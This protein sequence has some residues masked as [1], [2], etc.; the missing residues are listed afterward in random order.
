MQSSSFLT[1]HII[2]INIKKRVFSN[3]DFVYSD[4]AQRGHNWESFSETVTIIS[5]TNT[6]IKKANWIPR[7][8]SERESHWN[9][10]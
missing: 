9:Y 6:H 3:M 7:M 8:R 5:I 10:E 2:I 4:G 1:C